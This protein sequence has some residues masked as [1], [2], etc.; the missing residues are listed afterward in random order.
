MPGY[1]YILT[2]RKH[3]TLYTGV[4]ADLSARI[5]QH[6]QKLAS[7]FTAKYN[8]NRLVWYEAHDEISFAISR[9]KQIKKWRRN[10]KVKLIEEMNPDWDD[11]Y[12]RL[13]H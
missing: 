9:E 4:T 8:I 12:L 10:W 5:F 7:V 3:G 6:K 2:N 13:N 1:T 11:L